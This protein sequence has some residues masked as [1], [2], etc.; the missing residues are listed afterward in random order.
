LG[1][2]FHSFDPPCFC[3]KVR[4]EVNSVVEVY[5]GISEMSLPIGRGCMRVRSWGLARKR[6]GTERF[7]VAGDRTERVIPAGGMG[8]LLP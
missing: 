5:S 4:C 6:N 2:N 8:G 7:S 1:T 3:A